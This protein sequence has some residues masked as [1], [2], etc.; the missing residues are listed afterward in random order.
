MVVMA[1]VTTA[2]AGPLL[3][4]I[5]GRPADTVHL[6]GRLEEVAVPERT[7][8]WLGRRSAGSGASSVNR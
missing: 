5:V 6:F 4:W 3:S 2:M 7:A 8:N 1:I